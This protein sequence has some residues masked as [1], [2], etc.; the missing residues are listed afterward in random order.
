MEKKRK[1]RKYN[2][3]SI[4]NDIKF[5]L[6][7]EQICHKHNI[8]RRTLYRIKEENAELIDQALKE[9][10]SIKDINVS[11]ITSQETELVKQNADFEKI[12]QNIERVNYNNY[13]SNFY[14][15]ENI[16]SFKIAIAIEKEIEEAIDNIYDKKIIQNLR[17]LSASLS[18][19]VDLKLK[20]EQSNLAIEMIDKKNRY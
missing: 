12:T 18:I 15:E 9:E 14:I 16:K 13:N 19:L 20:I 3:L 17:T 7:N 8:S 2:I 10:L 6:T 1:K 11:E 5:N 4:I